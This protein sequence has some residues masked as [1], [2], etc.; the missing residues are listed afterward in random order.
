MMQAFPMLDDGVMAMLMILMRIMII[1]SG[2]A[3]HDGANFSVTSL[4]VSSWNIIFCSCLDACSCEGEHNC[5][6]AGRPELLHELLR[7]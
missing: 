5:R 4:H 3:T 6:P 7:Y 1:K 2:N